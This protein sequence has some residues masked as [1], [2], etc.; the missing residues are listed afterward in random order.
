MFKACYYPLLKSK[1]ML[2][3]FD[4]NEV[5]S[6]ARSISSLP[7]SFIN[8]KWKMQMHEGKKIIL[9]KSFLEKTTMTRIAEN[10]NCG[11][12]Y[13]GNRHRTRDGG[14]ECASSRDL[15]LHGICISEFAKRAVGERHTCTIRIVR[16]TILIVG[17]SPASLIPD[18]STFIQQEQ[19]RTGLL[20]P[21][22]S[23][24]SGER[25]IKSSICAPVVF[26]RAREKNR[27]CPR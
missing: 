10:R 18:R 5:C 24:V 6:F 1:C 25:L 8:V 2:S 22:L 7:S 11:A 16:R 20:R 15:F 21:F 26:D 14:H 23:V 17:T 12:F 27:R 3:Q 19:V 9:F 4:N 13:L